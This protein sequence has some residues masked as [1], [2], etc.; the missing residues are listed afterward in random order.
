[1]KTF[2]SHPHKPHFTKRTSLE[3]NGRQK[4][5]EVTDL[6][7]LTSHK[8]LNK[9]AKGALAMVFAGTFTFSATQAFAAETTNPQDNYQT[10]DIQTT[11]NTT[12]QTTQTQESTTPATETQD[13]TTQET[14]TQET[15]SLVPGDFFYFAKIALEKIRLALTFDDVKQAKLLADYSSE[16]LAEAQALFAS[17][18]QETAVKTINQALEDMKDADKL[19]ADQ[20]QTDPVSEQTSSTDGATTD[21]SSTT[22]Q[23]KDDKQV[24]E[25]NKNVEEVNSTISH[26]IAALTAAM[27]KVKNPVAKAALQRNIEK[28][29]AKIAKKMD[30]L[31]KKKTDEE[32]DKTS[33]AGDEN[34]T[35]VAEENVNGTTDTS[36]NTNTGSEGSTN[37]SAEPAAVQPATQ[38]QP[39]V[40][41]E[42]KQ[43]VK[44]EIQQK[45]EEVKTFVEQK[46]AEVK[47][48]AEE[49]KGNH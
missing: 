13:T 24:T 33:A 48:N 45:R 14:Q 49:H 17:G 7:K 6:K 26:N 12:E 16:R 34:S 2:F 10:V 41:H 28:S 44:Q 39:T 35:P 27:E 46:K 37:E 3:K 9:I 15:P 19:A 31:A 20:N 43:I 1:M 4:K 8:Q 18:D 47:Q 29:Y 5:L 32:T 25:E 38:T 23:A 36:V 42:N 22:D 40:K 21:N 11:A 30:K